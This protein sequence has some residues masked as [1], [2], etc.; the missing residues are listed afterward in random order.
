MA[1]SPL[2]PLAALLTAPSTYWRR[3]LSTCRSHNGLASPPTNLTQPAICLWPTPLVRTH[4][5]PFI[6]YNCH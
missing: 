6:F 2:M 1:I 5:R 3:P 4:P